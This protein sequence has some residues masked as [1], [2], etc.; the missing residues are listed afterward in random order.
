MGLGRRARG[1]RVLGEAH[2]AVLDALTAARACTLLLEAGGEAPAT[3]P[4]RL[5]VSERGG[6]GKA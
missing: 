3:P 4:A 5:A 1:N 2:S 6:V